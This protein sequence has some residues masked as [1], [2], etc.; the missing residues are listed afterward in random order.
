MK[1]AAPQDIVGAYQ[2]AINMEDQVQIEIIEELAPKKL[3]G[4]DYDKFSKL[5][6]K[7]IPQ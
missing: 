3:M 4:S 5:K 2:D 6:W 7:I 1:D